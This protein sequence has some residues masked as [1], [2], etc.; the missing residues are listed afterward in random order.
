VVKVNAYLSDMRDFP[1]FNEVYKEFFHE[2]YPCR[3]T[4]GA[5]VAGRF[6]VWR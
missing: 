5:R 4:V 1:A 6:D 3:T 2:P